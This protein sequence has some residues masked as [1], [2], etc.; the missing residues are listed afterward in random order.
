MLCN[1][2]RIRAPRIIKNM[3]RL[4]ILIMVALLPLRGWAGD[5]MSVQMAMGAVAPHVA[6]VMPADCPMHAQVAADASLSSGMD[7]C[8]C[9]DLCI[10]MAGL[11]GARLE[12]VAFTAHAAPTTAE[13]DF[14]SA[15]PAPTLRPP[16]S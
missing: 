2:P 16:I 8:V 3:K 6:S 7:G 1:A 15:S 11:T 13:V 12:V 14:V 5:L 9:C 10:L 4:F